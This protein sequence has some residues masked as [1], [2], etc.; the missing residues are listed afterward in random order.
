MILEVAVFSIAPAQKA[1]LPG[2]YQIFLRVKPQPSLERLL[3]NA[4]EQSEKRARAIHA[5]HA[6]RLAA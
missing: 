5:V 1:Q 6:T 3:K 2:W 4:E